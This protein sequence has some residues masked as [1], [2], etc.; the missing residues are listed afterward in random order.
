LRNEK[1]EKERSKFQENQGLRIYEEEM[2]ISFK[3]GKLI[4]WRVI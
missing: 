4:P 3:Q 2:E 1:L